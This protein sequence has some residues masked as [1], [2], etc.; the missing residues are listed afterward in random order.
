MVSSV[1]EGGW[2]K[3]SSGWKRDHPGCGSLRPVLLECLHT[4]LARPHRPA[5]ATDSPHMAWPRDAWQSLG[6]FHKCL[7]VK[8]I[9]V[10]TNGHTL[11]LRRLGCPRVCS[12]S[13]A[14]QRDLPGGPAFPPLPLPSPAKACK[15]VSCSQPTC[16]LLSESKEHALW[17]AIWVLE[18]AIPYL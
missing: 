12:N 15:M 5:S 7:R 4:P 6:S 16:H 13:S 9:L 10:V 8:E 3:H 2:G 17:R 18:K 11:L 1:E 14:V